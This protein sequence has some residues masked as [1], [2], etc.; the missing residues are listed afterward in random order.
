MVIAAEVFHLKLDLRQFAPSTD[1]ICEA[2]CGC[3]SIGQTWNLTGMSWATNNGP[4]QVSSQDGFLGVQKPGRDGVTNPYTAATE[5]I[6][7]DLAGVIGLPIPPVTL[8]DRGAAAGDPRFVAMSAWAFSSALTW[9]QAETLLTAEQKLSLAGAAS[10][11]LP[12]EVWVSAQD[13]QNPGNMLVD[14]N[15]VDNQARGAWIDYSFSLDYFWKGNLDVSTNVPQIYPPVGGLDVS[16]ARE[17]AT[18][19]SMVD[20]ATIEGIV[21]RVPEDYLPK[22][23]GQNIIRNLLA[24][25]APVFSAFK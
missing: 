15:L 6:V 14:G 8:W 9:A 5:K 22:A 21:N 20:P 13:R 19:I 3:A 12:F 10:A 2:W 17:A 23:A 16:R 1:A 11:V 7:A 24:R 4:L 18:A 25:Q